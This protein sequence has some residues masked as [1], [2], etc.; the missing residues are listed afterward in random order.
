[1]ATAK[2]DRKRKQIQRRGP[3]RPDAAPDPRMQKVGQPPGVLVHV[4]RVKVAEPRVDYLTYN[5]TELTRH[6][7]LPSGPPPEGQTAWFNLYG[8]QDTALLAHLGQCFDL[9]PLV[10]EDILNTEQRPKL[11]L[12]DGY[13]FLVSRLLR[14]SED[15]SCLVAD[16]VNF[17]LGRGWLI[18]VQEQPTGLFANVRERLLANHVQQRRGGADYLLYSLL[19]ALVDHHFLL[20]ERMGDQIEELEDALVARPDPERITS[21]YDRKRELLQLRRAMW[22]LRESLNGLVRDD[23]D[24]LLDETQLYV[25]DLY[26]HTV[27]AIESI[28]A[29][30]DQLSGLLDV[31]VSLTSNRLNQDMR[32][33][34]VITTIFMP[35]TLISSIYGMNFDHMPELHWRWGYFVALGAMAA[36]GVGLGVFFWRRKWL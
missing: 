20:I 25:R 11:E 29:L 19:D 34:T 15:G 24:F 17:V 8:L 30:R 10:L 1:M 22:P 36:I 23:G 26:D 3:S 12:Y 33:L 4:G 9:H 16:Q 7:G 6:S 5:E 32:V 27:Q 28:E 18:T 35:L 2:P 13:L 21:I 31:F 14:P